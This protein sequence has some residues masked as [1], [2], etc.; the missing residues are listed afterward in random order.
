[1]DHEQE[2]SL[3]GWETASHMV[4]TGRG[5]NIPELE[6]LSVMMVHT[7]RDRRSV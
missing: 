1:M 2:H 4:R 5:Q 3:T 7:G 6:K